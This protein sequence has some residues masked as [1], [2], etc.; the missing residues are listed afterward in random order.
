MRCGWSV[1]VETKALR[2]S[3][4]PSSLCEKV[5]RV[6]VPWDTFV[7]LLPVVEDTCICFL[8]KLL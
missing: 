1:G 8:S 7:G 6:P 3:L 4:A 5:L 2:W